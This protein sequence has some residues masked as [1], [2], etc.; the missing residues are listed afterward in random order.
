M[1]NNNRMR[2]FGM[3][4]GMDTSQLVKDMTATQR[5]KIE[6]I[7]KNQS[8]LKLRNDAWKDMNKKMYDFHTKFT[9]KLSQKSTFTAS[10]STSSDESVVTINNSDSAP[11]GTH[12]IKVDQLAETISIA[13][14]LDNP[15]GTLSAD[16]DIDF[17]V[18]QGSNVKSIT[19]K[20]LQGDTNEDIARKMASELKNAGFSANYADGVFFA[21]STKTGADEAIN[22]SSSSEA[23]KDLM[24]MVGLVDSDNKG[25]TGKDAVYQYNGEE[26]ASSTNQ[27]KVNGLD[28]TLKSTSNSNVMISSETNADETYKL[29]KEFVSEYNK[30]IEDISTKVGTRPDMSL[31]PLTSEE[32]DAMSKSDAKLWDDKINDSLFYRDKQLEQF[33]STARSSLSKAFNGK[34]LSSIGIVTGPWQEKGKLHIVGDEDDPSQTGKPNKLKEMIANDPSVVTDLINGISKNLY[35]SHSK[36]LGSNSLKS[37]LNFYNDKAMNE[38]MKSYD[39]QISNLESRLYKMEEM[40]HS[41]F[42]AMERMMQQMN[43]QSYWMSQQFGGY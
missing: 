7:Q 12:K 18:G 3:A 16:V 1:I 27:V 25:V 29:I 41:K 43:S 28:L 13:K 11:K 39:K 14:R 19:V 15:T 23:A 42:S 24:K 33:A 5:Y 21:N 6:S 8:L 10:K 22:I 4:S 32:R 34:T 26:F 36:S 2:L 38:Q 35:E 30:L 20:A 31:K 40:Y 9:H 37:A 17:Q